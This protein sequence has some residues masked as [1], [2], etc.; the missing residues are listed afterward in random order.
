[1]YAIDLSGV[2]PPVDVFSDKSLFSA[3]PEGAHFLLVLTGC[4]SWIMLRKTKPLE[5][6]V[7]SIGYS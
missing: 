6:G 5:A 4:Y 3:V 2:S 1:M 7:S